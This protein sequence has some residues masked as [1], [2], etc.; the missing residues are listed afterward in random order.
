[1]ALDGE[2]DRA[3]FDLGASGFELGTTGG[4]D[5]FCA[6]G[7]GIAGRANLQEGRATLRRDG[8]VLHANSVIAKL[9]LGQSGDWGGDGVGVRGA[10]DN[11][12]GV[13]AVMELAHMMAAQIKDGKFKP[14]QNIAFAVWSGEEI[15]ILGSSQFVKNRKGLPISAYLNMDMI[16]RLR[17]ELIVQGAG[18][19]KAWRGL[20]EKLLGHTE[21]SIAVQD[22]PYLPTDAMAFYLQGIPSISFFTGSHSEYHT[23]R[24]RPETLNIEG[25]AQVATTVGALATELANQKIS[26]LHYQ[27]VEGKSPSSEG[28]SFRLYLGT[29]PDYSSE[30]KKGV[31]ISGTSKNSPAEKAGLIA[32]DIIVEMGGV[33][34]ENIYDYVYCLQAMKANEKT[35]MKVVRKDNVVELE[36]VPALKADQ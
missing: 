5:E 10:D 14:K 6:G 23:P 35:P 29:I 22:D 24:D 12:S 7:N 9:D 36:I 26:S 11:A 8:D 3:A 27:K 19:A 1:M 21:M 4:E 28:R 16:G 18:S 31:K 33:K 20:I 32:G 2:H 30:V 13:S 34:I 17:S 25:I 15:G